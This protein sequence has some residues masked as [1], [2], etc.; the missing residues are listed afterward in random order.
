VWKSRA[1]ALVGALDSE[2]E[3]KVT[4][5]TACKCIVEFLYMCVCVCVCV[6]VCVCVC[7]ITVYR[8]PIKGLKP[9]PILSMGI[10]RVRMCMFGTVVEEGS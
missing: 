5:P 1:E 4:M 7:L 10:G 8:S 2:A 9:D 3:W 6:Y